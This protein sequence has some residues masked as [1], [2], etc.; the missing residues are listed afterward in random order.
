MERVTGAAPVASALEARHWLAPGILEVRLRRPAGF[1]FIPGQFARL[2]MDDYV[3]DYTMVSGPKDDSLVFC[4]AVVE[5]GR[6]SQKILDSA[7]GTPF[8]LTGPHGHF[9]YQGTVNPPVFVATGTGI[10]PFAAFGRS[11]IGGDALLLHGAGSPDQLIYRDLLQTAVRNY[12]PCVSRPCAA[13]RLPADAF[14][15]RVTR[16]LEQRLESGRYDFYLCGR[17]AMIRDATA[18]IDRRFGQSRLFIETYD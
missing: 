8:L 7:V 1:D 14:G 10:A 12:V 17:R 2:V 11:G 4:I 6:F 16:Y 13:G 9:V 15:G 3:R 5:K 18:I